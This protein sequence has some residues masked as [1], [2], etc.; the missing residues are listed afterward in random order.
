MGDLE[1]ER[2]YRRGNHCGAGE[3]EQLV[4]GEVDVPLVADAV[5]EVCQ[6]G[7][8]VGGEG[9]VKVAPVRLEEV[10]VSSP[11]R[12]GRVREQ[13]IVPVHPVPGELNVVLPALRS[14]GARQLLVED[15]SPALSVDGQARVLGI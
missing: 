7:R 5:G 13:D 12:G 2:V 8:V 11:V 4:R 3:V 15:A 9:A 6:V 10:V 14:G 1:E